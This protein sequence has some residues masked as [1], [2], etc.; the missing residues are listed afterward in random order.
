MC[1][2]DRSLDQLILS[3]MENIDDRFEVVERKG[4]GRP[5]TICD[6]LADSLSCALRRE[7]QRRS[8]EIPHHNV[9]KVVLSSG[10]TA[11]EF[12][13]GTVM[14]LLLLRSISTLQDR[15]SQK[16]VARVYRLRIS[17]LKPR[18]HGLKPISTHWMR[19]LFKLIAP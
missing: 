11:P 8:G 19:N 18:V 5:D 7:Y 1:Q 17:Q 12:N 4:L 10:A 9:D 14:A 2:K 15:Q 13:G 16:W 6:A 3:Q